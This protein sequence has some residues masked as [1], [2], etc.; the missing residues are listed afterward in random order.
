L[1]GCARSADLYSAS[2]AIVPRSRIFNTQRF[3][4]LAIAAPL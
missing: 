4:L 3:V 2:T 1:L